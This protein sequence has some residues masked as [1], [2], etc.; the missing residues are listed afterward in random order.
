MQESIIRNELEAPPSGGA[1]RGVRGLPR[2]IKI[3][4]DMNKREYI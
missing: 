2:R 3:H 4:V 1:D